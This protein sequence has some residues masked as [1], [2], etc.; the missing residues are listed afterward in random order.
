MIPFSA[1]VLCWNLWIFVNFN[2]AFLSLGFLPL[3]IS[4]ERCREWANGRQCCTMKRGENFKISP[5][6]RFDIP[7]AWVVTKVLRKTDIELFRVNH[8]CL[9]N[10]GIASI[11]ESRKCF[12][13]IVRKSISSIRMYVD[14]IFLP[15]AWF[16]WRARQW[17]I[18]ASALVFGHNNND[19]PL[20]M[21]AFVVS[22]V[23]KCMKA[24]G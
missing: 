20:S 11:Y 7:D 9:F 24:R 13:P 10:I 16:K 8:P 12:P 6:D 17:K 2:R 15:S 5:T 18:D 1:N 14:L 4:C 23:Q 22:H 3:E 21:N 19:V